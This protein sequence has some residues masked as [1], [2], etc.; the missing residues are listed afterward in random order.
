MFVNGFN[1]KQGE[2]AIHFSDFNIEV[3]ED[4]LKIIIDQEYSD[5]YSNKQLKHQVLYKIKLDK[6]YDTIAAYSNGELVPFNI[7]LGM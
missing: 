1:I 4:L 7:I 3:E 6:E 5:D 2:K